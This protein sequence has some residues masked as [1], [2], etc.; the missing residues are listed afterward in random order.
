M[1]PF[2]YKVDYDRFQ[3]LWYTIIIAIGKFKEPN[4]IGIK[5]IEKGIVKLYYNDDLSIYDVELFYDSFYDS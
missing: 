4:E 3:G 2:R 1:T 5:K